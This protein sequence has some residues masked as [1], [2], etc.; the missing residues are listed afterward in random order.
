MAQ[1]LTG[2]TTAPTSPYKLLTDIRGEPIYDDF[3]Q[4][5][6]M[7]GPL[8]L[9]LVAADKWHSFKDIFQKEQNLAKKGPNLGFLNE[10]F[11]PKNYDLGKFVSNLYSAKPEELLGVTG[12][13]MSAEIRSLTN[14]DQDK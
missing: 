7:C 14:L 12:V 6:S 2:S 9:R 3:L 11:I 5:I 13:N 10:L 4:Y 1:I 8:N